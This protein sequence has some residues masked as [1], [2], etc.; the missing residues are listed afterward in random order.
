MHDVEVA[1]DLL[2]EGKEPLGKDIDVVEFDGDCDDILRMP[3]HVVEDWILAALNVDFYKNRTPRRQTAE[4]VFDG[5]A[6]VPVVAP[7][8][9]PEMNFISSEKEYV[10][11]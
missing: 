2:D 9:L 1:L 7:D 4:R 8:S 6:V 5:R 11:D 3:E 10:V